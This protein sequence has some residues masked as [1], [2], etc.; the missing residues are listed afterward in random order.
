L[1]LGWSTKNTAAIEPL[2]D[3][4]QSTADSIVAG[5][6]TYEEYIYSQISAKDLYYLEDEDLARQLVELGYRCG[7]LKSEEFEQR[8]KNA[9]N[10]K[11]KKTNNLLPKVLA[12]SGREK[13]IQD[14]A[15]L[16]ALAEREE[17]VRT[18]KLAV[19][20]CIHLHKSLRCQKLRSQV[21]LLFF[22]VLYLL[23][24]RTKRDKKLAV[25]SIM[26]TD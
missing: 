7:E 11:S 17:M 10:M 21:D 14:S 4:L 15:F 23:E 24:T 19:C 6:A 1:P 25:T 13:D 2:M 9:E 16:Q 26:V 12:S 20:Q 3:A 5:Y 22:S 8:K 18:G